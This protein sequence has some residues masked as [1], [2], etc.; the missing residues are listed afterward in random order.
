MGESWRSSP[1]HPELVFLD[2]VLRVRPS[3]SIFNGEQS[4]LAVLLSLINSFTLVSMLPT[5]AAI[6]LIYYDLVIPMLIPL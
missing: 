2:L 4:R 5:D 3:S 6:P 1:R